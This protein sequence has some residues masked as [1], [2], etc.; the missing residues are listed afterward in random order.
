MIY[1][2]KNK[3]F[4]GQ[5]WDDDYTLNPNGID[6]GSPTG[7]VLDRRE[8]TLQLIGDVRGKSVLDLGGGPLLGQRLFEL[9]AARVFLIDISSIACDKAKQLCDQIETRVADAL[10]YLRYGRVE[11]FDVVTAIGVLSYTQPEALDLLFA[12]CTGKIVILSAA[13]EGY[14]Q[15]TNRITIHTHDDMK[16]VCKQYGWVVDTD[17]SSA[18][19]IFASYR[20]L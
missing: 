2:S 12:R 18:E 13:C 6:Y 1:S 8:H 9:G 14:L 10:E 11:K 19:H 20:R 3:P 4:T 5:Q 15:Y 17:A 16:R 7:S